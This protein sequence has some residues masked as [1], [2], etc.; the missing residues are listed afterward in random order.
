MLLNGWGVPTATDISLAWMFALLIF[1]AG[2][3]AINFLLLLAIADDALGMAII[4]AFYGNPEKPV[5]PVW[6][7]LV[8]VAMAV[9]FL[10]R[11]LKVQYWSLYVMLSGP[12]SWLG[13]I[14]AHVHP[15]LAL[16]FVVPFMPAMHDLPDPGL[17]YGVPGWSLAFLRK[18][19]YFRFLY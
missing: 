1:G 16:V 12:I 19:P 14:L 5:E 18:T 10:L 3:P 15:A 13:L 4:A 2:H 17:R 9:A 11:C 6:L 8:L 7:L